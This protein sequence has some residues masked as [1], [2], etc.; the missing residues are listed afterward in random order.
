NRLDRSLTR[1]HYL[2]SGDLESAPD[3]HKP[4]GE[5]RRQ[6][7]LYSSALFRP[8]SMNERELTSDSLEM[9]LNS[10]FSCLEQVVERTESFL[11]SRIQNEDLIYRVVLLATE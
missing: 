10:D 4:H 6:R 2:H 7:R 5:R 11:G 9:V 1:M 8:H 3:P